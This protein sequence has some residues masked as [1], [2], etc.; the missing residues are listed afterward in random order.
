[1]FDFDEA[2]AIA[3]KYIYQLYY[4]DKFYLMLDTM[5]GDYDYIFEILQHDILEGDLKVPD[6]TTSWIFEHGSRLL[7]GDYHVVKYKEN[8]SEILLVVKIIDIAGTS[9]KL[10]FA[11]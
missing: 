7:Y 11:L 1:M 9:F 3:Y 8:F 6:D 10:G 5:E 4:P 2:K